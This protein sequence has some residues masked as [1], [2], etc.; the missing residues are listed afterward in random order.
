MVE[1]DYRTAA[2][3]VAPSDKDTPPAKMKT[4]MPRFQT[5]VH[6]QHGVRSRARDDLANRGREPLGRESCGKF[7]AF[8][9]PGVQQMMQLSSGPDR[10]NYCAFGAKHASSPERRSFWCQVNT[11]IVVVGRSKRD[12][13]PVRKGESKGRGEGGVGRRA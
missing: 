4:P 8:R 11:W 5:R 13:Q 7:T 9:W 10:T 12:T 1:Q 2:A 6:P 3:G